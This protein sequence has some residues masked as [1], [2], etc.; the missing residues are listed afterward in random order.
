MN[1]KVIL[2]TGG[3]G[4]IGTN[5]VR[6]LSERFPDSKI[7]VVDLLTYAGNI[8]NIKDLID[9][10]KITFIQVDISDSQKVFDVFDKYSFD[11]IVN[12]AAES[13][14]DR[15]IIDSKRFIET[16]VLGTQTL[17]E[18]ARRSW[19]EF[20]V[21]KDNALFLQ[22]STDEVYGSIE[23]GYFT[24]KTPLD[25]HSPYS[26]SKASADLLVKSYVDT[27]GFPAVITR[28]SNNYGPYQFPEKLIPLMIHNIVTGKKLPVYG[29]GKNVRDWIHVSDHCNAIMKIL[30]NS[31]PGEI[32]NI[33]SNNE[34]SNIDLVKLLIKVVR[35]EMKENIE[36]QRFAKI[37]SDEMTDDL[38]E[39]VKDRPGHDKRYAI[40]NAKLKKDIGWEPKISF[41]Q[42]L[43]DT[44]RW[45]LSNHD[46]V[47]HIVSGEYKNYYKNMYGKREV[48]K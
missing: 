9:S 43:K 45:Y 4:F 18:A 35:E 39:F 30:N 3:A 13:H 2:V 46:W 28:C 34:W 10:E 36:F 15:S 29:D 11:H 41:E 19:K 22:V 32:Y 31:D 48:L 7:V 5:F 8:E 40:S 38:I 16:N 27:Y 25:P 6:L 12:F 26:A 44:V 23:K 14:V 17:L 33:G 24:E 47:E 1:G 37:S 42:G 20:N 21:F